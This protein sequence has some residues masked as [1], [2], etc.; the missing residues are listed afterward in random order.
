MDL[1]GTRFKHLPSRLKKLQ[2][3]LACF[4]S[5]II[6][7]FIEQGSWYCLWKI[8][9]CRKVRTPTLMTWMPCKLGAVI[10]LSKWRWLTEWQN[11][12]WIIVIDLL[13][14][15]LYY[16]VVHLLFPLDSTINYYCVCVHI[17]VLFICWIIIWLCCKKC[18]LFVVPSGLN[19]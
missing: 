2:I 9:L 19:H 13:K 15:C 6:R 17:I 11:K 4:N 3:I 14:S 1:S 16:C 8:G 7:F 5:I 12:G 10:W 18:P